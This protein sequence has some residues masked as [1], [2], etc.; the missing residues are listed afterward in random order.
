VPTKVY[1]LKEN[2]STYVSKNFQVREFACNDGSDAILIAD[3]LI[4]TLQKIRD[5]FGKP[6]VINSAYRTEEYNKKVGGAP[7][8]QHVKGTAADIV[9]AGVDPI[10]VAQYAEFLLSGSGGIGVYPTFTHV[11]VRPS[12]ARWDNRSGREVAVSGWPGYAELT[13][14]DLAIAW[15]QAKGIMKGDINGDLMLEQPLT[16]RQFAV[17]LYR[18]DQQKK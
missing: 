15:V 6:V 7:K 17:M 1:S 5:H 11:D 18:Y 14:S 2:G 8:S 3:A 10:A 12:R 4:E 13:E 9:V 16:R